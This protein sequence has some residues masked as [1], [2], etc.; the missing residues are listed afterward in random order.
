MGNAGIHEKGEIA[1]VQSD[2]KASAASLFHVTTK[3]QWYCTADQWE[4]LPAISEIYPG[5][6]VAGAGQSN[7]SILPAVDDGSG[8]S[9]GMM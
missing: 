1:W 7:G 5:S 9:Q 6:P 3:V 8:E 2:L 4:Q